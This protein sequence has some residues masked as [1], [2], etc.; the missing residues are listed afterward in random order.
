M[1]KNYIISNGCI[2]NKKR[3]VKKLLNMFKFYFLLLMFIPKSAST[4][5][6]ATIGLPVS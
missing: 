2:N 1:I 5:S 6:N 3:G 4:K